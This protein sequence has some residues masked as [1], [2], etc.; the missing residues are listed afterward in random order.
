MTFPGNC[1][2]LQACDF[3]RDSQAVLYTARQLS[4]AFRGKV[5][6]NE[7]WLECKASF[8]TMYHGAPERPNA[9]GRCREKFLAD[10]QDAIET[11][12]R[13]D[14]A[15]IVGWQVGAHRSFGFGRLRWYGEF[16]CL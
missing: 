16:C 12:G 7:S 1:M 6:I 3:S 9:I 11:G 2:V 10:A 13:K 8:L 4:F 5:A 14:L 15:I